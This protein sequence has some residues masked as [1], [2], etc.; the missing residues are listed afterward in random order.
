MPPLPLTGGETTGIILC[1]QAMLSA[2]K[3]IDLTGQRFT[4]L[5]VLRRN[6]HRGEKVAWLCRCDC[7]KQVQVVADQL[8]SGRTK[9][10][11]C[12]SR[13]RTR[14]ALTRHGMTG[15]ALH[16]KWKGMVSRCA[17]PKGAG[18]QNYG[19]RGIKVCERWLIFENFRDD[20]GPSF[21]AGLTI[22]RI[23]VGGDYEPAN[24]RWMPRSNQS[25]N[26]R[27][28]SSWQFKQSGITTNTSG[29]RGVSPNYRTGG[30]TASI[31][32]NGK[33]KRLGRF[34]TKEAAYS[35]YL[36]ASQERKKCR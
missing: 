34:E 14:T 24:C 19:G 25:A 35:A 8:R 23:D 21:K 31:C 13:D 15:H 27:A 26:R 7:G 28:G 17:N 22:D 9:S 6:G 5:L 20:M 10:C 11:G 33:Q 30:W 3:M 36:A 32:I 16:T 29:Y 12:W 4:R 1:G 18:F 2:M